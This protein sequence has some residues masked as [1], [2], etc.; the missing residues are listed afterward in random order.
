[1]GLGFPERGDGGGVLPAL[2]FEE[3]EDQP[4][5]AVLGILGTTVAVRLDERIERAAFDVVSVDAVERRAA[6]GVLLEEREEALQGALFARLLR[7]G[8]IVRSPIGP[9]CPR[10]MPEAERQPDD[11]PTEPELT[12]RSRMPGHDA[13]LEIYDADGLPTAATAASTILRLS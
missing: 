12:S 5:G 4:G 2:E 11:D 8:R 9:L 6:P 7:G 10:R 13:T 3:S 1:M